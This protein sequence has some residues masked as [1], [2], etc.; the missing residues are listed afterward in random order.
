M[1][2]IYDALNDE[3]LKKQTQF[4][5]PG[6]LRGRGFENFEISPEID[7]TELFETDDLHSPE[8]V[9]KQSLDNA[10]KV[11]GADK[12]YY[13][14]NGSTAGVLSMVLG[15]VSEGEK[16]IADR[17]CHKSFVSA[18]ALSG[19][20]PVW[21]KPRLVENGTMWS[22]CTIEDIKKA[23]E[24]NPDAKALYITAPN[25]F[26]LMED[27]G[28]IAALAH[29][30]GMYLL[31]DGAHGAHYGMSD[32][33]PPSIISMGADA[34]CMSLHKTLP[35]LTQTAILLT[36]GVHQRLEGALRAV[37]TSSPSYIFSSSC[38]Y[39]V[40]YY[41][42]CPK[43]KWDA[44]YAAVKKYFPEQLECEN[45]K[46]K[47]FSRLNIKTKGSGFKL[48]E[49]LREKYN[50]AVEC[51]YGGGVVVILTPFH[52]EEEIKA[53]R[54]AVDKIQLEND[55]IKIIPFEARCVKSPR[56]AF[57]AKKKWVKLL[58]AVGKISAEGIMVY[59]PGIYQLLP[60]EEIT[61]EAVD[62]INMLIEK[63]ADVPSVKKSNCLI[64]E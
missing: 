18:L 15:F 35:S 34:V 32:K 56:E 47:D 28:A 21:V 55:E 58:D 6:H 5:M 49:I 29:E 38:E 25:Y 19:A 63:G 20:V 3:K 43:E 36:H 41:E 37:Q 2:P 23:M 22:G 12:A 60:G 33:L 27:V 17:F 10:A 62:A 42:K 45:V 26:G 52:T 61:K 8:T 59:P 54:A 24:D 1:R 64:F 30:K 40:E 16:I 39:A 9:I 53:L 46:Y 13:L 48:Q 31:V 57:F 7:V 4:H 44:L 14:V 11:F 51:A 50:I